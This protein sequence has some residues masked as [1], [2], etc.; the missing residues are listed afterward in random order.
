MIP[1]FLLAISISFSLTA[2]ALAVPRFNEP[3]ARFEP[4]ERDFDRDSERDRRRES[5]P[6]TMENANLGDWR[7]FE[8]ESFILRTLELS[9]NEMQSLTRE[10]KHDSTQYRSLQR[11]IGASLRGPGGDKALLR[12][13]FQLMTR[14]AGGFHLSP[15]EL[16]TKLQHWNPAAKEHLGRVLQTA[17][18]L[19]RQGRAA[20]REQAFQ[21]GLKK[22]GLE[23]KYRENCGRR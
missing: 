6:S 15:V 13:Y 1:R 22:F 3:R 2:S 16:E 5:N 9:R 18:Q 20:T 23:S 17:A 4:R 14:C 19:A 7:R 21:L 10:F 8:K 11:L 12:G